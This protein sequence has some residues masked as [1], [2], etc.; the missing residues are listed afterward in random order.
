MSICTFCGHHDAPD[1]IR[2]QVREAIEQ[3]ITTKEVDCFYVGNHGSFDRIALSVLRELKEE[4]PEIEYYVVLAYLAE[5]KEEYPRYNEGETLLPEG[6]ENIPKRFA[7]SYRNKWMVEHSD[8]MISY[9]KHNFGGA[10]KT[11]Q[12]AKNHS[13]V[14]LEL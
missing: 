1:T 5:K 10:R 8:Y 7:I 4:H 14:I 11:L 3:L 12:L 2:N 13:L 9:V 6:I